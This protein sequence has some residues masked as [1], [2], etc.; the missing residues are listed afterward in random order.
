MKINHLL[1]L[2]RLLVKIH[3]KKRIE[4]GNKLQVCQEVISYI[5]YLFFIY[6]LNNFLTIISIKKLIRISI[7]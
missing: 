3:K 4:M 7:I 2:V 6:F 1:N 5:F